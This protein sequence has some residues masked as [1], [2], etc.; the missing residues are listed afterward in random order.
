M[1]NRNDQVETVSASLE[2]RQQRRKE[3]KAEKAERNRTV[4]QGKEE[5]KTLKA[6]LPSLKKDYDPEKWRVTFIEA[7]LACN[8]EQRVEELFE[9][10]KASINELQSMPFTSVDDLSTFIDSMIPVFRKDVRSRKWKNTGCQFRVYCQWLYTRIQNGYLV[11]YANFDKDYDQFKKAIVCR[12]TGNEEDDKVL[13]EFAE[14][15]ALLDF[16]SYTYLAA[17]VPGFKFDKKT[18][19]LSLT[20]DAAKRLPLR[21]PIFTNTLNSF[22]PFKIDYSRSVNAF[23]CSSG[24]GYNKTGFVVGG[25]I[26]GARTMMYQK[27]FNFAI[28]NFQT[29]C[30]GYV[31]PN[32]PIH[33]VEVFEVEPVNRDFEHN[34][35]LDDEYDRSMEQTKKKDLDFRNLGFMKTKMQGS[36]ATRPIVDYEEESKLK[37]EARQARA[38][39]EEEQNRQES[40]ETMKKQIQEE[41]KSEKLE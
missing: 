18:E 21:L 1:S 22:N 7:N 14:K 25:P 32:N 5:R 33:Q 9:N 11:N 17:T 16:S 3:K 19:I 41:T 38:E 37:K 26:N 2:E 20:S 8:G 6:S 30:Q 31:C 36:V 4:M 27:R 40:E 35:M 15:E 10:L 28:H 29:R 24:G 23:V 39:E 34:L 12:V 13:R